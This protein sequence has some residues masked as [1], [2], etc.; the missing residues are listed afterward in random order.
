MNKMKRKIGKLIAMVLIAVMIIPTNPVEAA[1]DYTYEPRTTYVSSGS[2][3]AIMNIK[4]ANLYNQCIVYGEAVNGGVSSW[5]PKATGT[6][7]CD[8]EPYPGN[9]VY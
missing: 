5:A 2:N 9:K 1:T 3:T 7:F 8:M 6:F 4:N